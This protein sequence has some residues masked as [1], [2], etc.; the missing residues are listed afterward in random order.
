MTLE[1]FGDHVPRVA[2]TAFVH[3][4]AVII[5]DVE[6]G[7]YS[8]VWPGAVLRGDYGSIRVGERTSIQ[9]NAV[10]HATPGAGTRVGSRCVIGHLAFLEDALVEDLC[11]VGVGS[12]ILNGARMRTGSVAAAGTV[13]LGSMEVPSGS[14]AQGVPARIE[15]ITRPTPDEI[16]SNADGYVENAR[17]MAASLARGGVSG[18]EPARSAS[19]G[20]G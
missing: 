1:P 4:T 13:L 6:I 12:K 20:P 15:A 11:L 9:D 5:G 8:S 3:P 7:A 16:R 10:V 17:R 2:A 14:R 18:R 19:S